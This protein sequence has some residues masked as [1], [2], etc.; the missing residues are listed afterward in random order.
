[1]ETRDR[2]AARQIGTGPRA[3]L[4]DIDEVDPLG[5]TRAPVVPDLYPAERTGAVVVHGESGI[6]HGE[7][8]GLDPAAGHVA[9]ARSLQQ[10][11]RTPATKTLV[12]RLIA[13]R[14]F[15][16]QVTGSAKLALWSHDRMFPT[17]DLDQQ[18][19]TAAERKRRRAAAGLDRRGLKQVACAMLLLFGGMVLVVAVEVG[20]VE[21]RLT[22]ATVVGLTDRW[23]QKGAHECVT[24]LFTG[25]GTARIFTRNMCSQAAWHIG[26]K[27]AVEARQS[28]LTRTIIV[29]TRHTIF[30]GA[31]SV[32]PES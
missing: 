12:V 18:G 5:A 25:Y 1:M 13:R 22:T 29:S 30:E 7:K 26:D 11:E 21:R 32:L 16:L 3:G 20:G 15:S 28:R 24:E 6:G 2:I 31:Y 9:E 17:G 8:V 4:G 27:A 19:E 14:A 10:S 23:Y